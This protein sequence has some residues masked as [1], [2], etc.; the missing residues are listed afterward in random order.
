MPHWNQ[1]VRADKNMAYD[2][3]KALLVKR[4][5]ALEDDHN[6]WSSLNERIPTNHIFVLSDNPEG[7]DSR[8]WGPVPLEVIRG[9]LITRI[10]RRK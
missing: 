5:T 10:S 2:T 9:V 8:S 6:R 3:T 4:L 7:R 1:M